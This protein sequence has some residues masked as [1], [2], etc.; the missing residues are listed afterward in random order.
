MLEP[1]K[2]LLYINVCV[3]G[4]ASL[5]LLMRT[6]LCLCVEGDWRQTLMKEETTTV[7]WMWRSALRC[8]SRLSRTR[9]R[10]TR[11]TC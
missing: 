10:R 7:W 3:A 2:G 9:G 4:S 8:C 1:K 6:S 5:P 11:S